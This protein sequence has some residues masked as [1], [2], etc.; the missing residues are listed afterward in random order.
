MIIDCHTHLLPGI[1]DGARNIDISMEML[2]E[3]K[4]Q[5]IDL[6]IAT[7]HFYANRDKI[8]N[9]IEKREKA[10]NKVLAKNDSQGDSQGTNIPKI[11]LGA[12]VAFFSGIS[13]SNE[14]GRLCVDGTNTILIEMPFD[15]WNSKVVGEIED[16]VTERGFNVVLVHIERFLGFKGNE[17]IIERLLEIPVTLQMNVEC[18]IQTGIL[19]KKKSKKML[20]YIETGKVSLLGSDCHNME[21]RKPNLLSGREMLS[22]DALHRIDEV[23]EKIFGSN[24]S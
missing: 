4:K 7:P 14:I 23:G 1:D 10:L 8:E 15:S 5:G 3:E 24:L 20:E 6:V 17:E 11:R 16:L 19:G 2:Q 13:K 22:K 21:T 18:L 9:F 12:E